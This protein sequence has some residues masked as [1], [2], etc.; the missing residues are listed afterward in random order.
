[1]ASASDPMG[2]P[3]VESARTQGSRSRTNQP[4]TVQKRRKCTR[5][6]VIFTLVMLSAGWIGRLLDAATGAEAGKGVGLL[7]W[8]LAP[9][10]TAA[11]LRFWGGDGWGDAGLRPRFR[12]NGAW[13]AVSL[14]LYPVILGIAVGAGL[15]FG[16]F[17]VKS[18]GDFP[19][20][21]FAAAFGVGL[22]PAVLT[23][24]AEEFGWRGYLVPRLDA[25]G[26]GRWINHLAIGLVWGTWHLPYVAVFWDY[27]DESLATLLPRIL[28]GL[29]IVAVVYGEIRLATGSVWPAVAMHAMGNAFVGGLLADEVLTIGSARPIVFSPGADGLFVIGLT[30]VVVPAVV[31]A[32]RRSDAHGGRQMVPVD[33][34]KPNRRTDERKRA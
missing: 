7:V 17:D 25:K 27:T 34:M 15:G 3:G 10:G 1:M 24:I 9:I 31:V 14:L 2:I 32:A 4:T 8:I 28:L 5:N 22:V 33:I 11:V 20:G 26:V 6:I 23:S 30:A 29:V 13:Y 21:S 19:F 18:G 12:G 16:A